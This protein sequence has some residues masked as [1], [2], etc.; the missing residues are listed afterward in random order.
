MFL[1]VNALHALGPSNA[2]RDDLGMPKSVVYGGVR[3]ARVSSQ[4]WKHAIREDW[5]RI[6]DHNR[7]AVRTLILP[8]LIVAAAK[9]TDA[10]NIPV[11]DPLFDII[12]LLFD[13]TNGLNLSL[14]SR[15]EGEE[16]K[17]SSMYLIGRPTIQYLGDK[18]NEYAKLVGE[19]E[20]KQ[21]IKQDL[22][23]LQKRVKKD[24]T[25]IL[26]VALFGRMA[27]DNKSLTTDGIVQYAHAIG[28][29]P[30]DVESDWYTAVD[31]MNH[32]SGAGMMGDIAY[33]TP[34][35][36]RHA[37]LNLSELEQH[38]GDLTADMVDAFLESFAMTVPSGKQTSFA[39]ATFPSLLYITVT[40]R[41]INMELAFEQPV[42]D[43]PINTG[44]DRLIEFESETV[45]GMWGMIPQ[46]AW[47]VAPA[48]RNYGVLG[49]PMNFQQLRD[50]VRSMISGE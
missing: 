33:D 47:L 49:E 1:N 30:Y 36:Y 26:D 7:L 32:A 2:N 43:N 37:N 23:D 10:K 41:P 6:I 5:N 34:T 27:A 39:Q 22:S 20:I 16:L 4:S 40:T 38:A 3:R 13:K 17:L 21:A 11:D 50:Q 31:D 19:K 18:L 28:I 48:T 25:N 24:S 46:H 44:I 29:T 9:H 35:Y 8:R 15:K 12:P 14:A 42:T 45:E